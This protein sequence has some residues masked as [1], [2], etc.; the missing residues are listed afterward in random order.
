MISMEMEIEA[1]NRVEANRIV[2]EKMAVMPENAKL[3]DITHITVPD[4][5][6]IGKERYVRTVICRYVA[7]AK[8]EDEAQEIFDNGEDDSDE[9]FESESIEQEDE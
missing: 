8:N 5:N 9:Y 1:P 6:K 7:W 2:K 4:E 3:R